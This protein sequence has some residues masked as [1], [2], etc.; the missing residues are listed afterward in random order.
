MIPC[1]KFWW[2]V[3]NRH[4]IHL[5]SHVNVVCTWYL[6]HRPSP[7]PL[8]RRGWYGSFS[9]ICLIDRNHL[10]YSSSFTAAF[11]T[12]VFSLLQKFWFN[13]VGV[14]DLHIFQY[15]PQ[16]PI[17]AFTCSFPDSAICRSLYPF[18][19]ALRILTFDFID[20]GGVKLC[21]LIDDVT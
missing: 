15:R 11:W 13:P 12:R 21:L 17:S 20:D 2:R 5:L 7:V 1:A 9:R 3:C 19:Q 18:G 10:I 6:Q 14:V 16:A 4:D 8:W